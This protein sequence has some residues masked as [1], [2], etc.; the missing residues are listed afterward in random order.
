MYASPPSST[1]SFCYTLAILN[2]FLRPTSTLGSGELSRDIEP[3]DYVHLDQWIVSRLTVVS[4]L[5]ILENRYVVVRLFR[6]TEYV[7]L[8][9]A[10]PHH[11]IPQLFDALSIALDALST[12]TECQDM[13]PIDMGGSSPTPPPTP[14]DYPLTITFSNSQTTMDV[15]VVEEVLYQNSAPADESSLTLLALAHCITSM[16]SAGC[17]DDDFIEAFRNASHEYLS[18]WFEFVN[19]DLSDSE[20]EADTQEED[21]ILGSKDDLELGLA[22]QHPE[23][24]GWI[25]VSEDVELS[26][27]NEEFQRLSEVRLQLAADLRSSLLDV[28][29]TAMEIQ[30]FNTRQREHIDGDDGPGVFIDFQDD[31]KVKQDVADMIH[32]LER[33]SYVR[34]LCRS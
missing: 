6:D 21:D 12:S 29:K 11:N 34:G 5:S 4:P 30:A 14:C 26:I 13:M 3:T 27:I 28:E 16:P 2:A 31:V 15:D 17:R 24:L 10:P 20:S 23:P 18:E 25:D 9:F 32:R 1:S 33:P 22:T 19:H 8:R 7:D